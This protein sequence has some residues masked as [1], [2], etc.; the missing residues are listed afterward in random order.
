LAL[1][2]D[3]KQALEKLAA[4]KGKLAKLSEKDP[5]RAQEKQES[6]QWKKAEALASGLKVK[7]DDKLLKKAVQRKAQ[8][9]QK[10]AKAWQDRIEKDK[11]TKAIAQKKRQDN[12]VQ[13]KNNKRPGF[14]GKA[15]TSKK[16]RS[17]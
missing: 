14:E 6:Y 5:E 13:R 1:P 4:Q 10:S 17:K 8:Q 9:K 15:F 12:I 7:D 3:P 11:R 2:S 16:P